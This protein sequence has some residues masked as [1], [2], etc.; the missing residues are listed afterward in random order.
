MKIPSNIHFLFLIVSVLALTVACRQEKKNKDENKISTGEAMQQ[1]SSKDWKQLF[2]KND[3]ELVID[4]DTISGED[5]FQVNNGKIKAMYRY[6]D[7]AV[8]PIAMII[9]KKKYSF[10]DL[11][12][13]YKWGNRKFRPRLDRKRDAGVLLHATTIQKVWPASLEYQIQEGDVGD[14][15]ALLGMHANV[16]KND[17]LIK[18][19]RKD[20]SRMLKF[21]DVEQLGWNKILIEVRGTA[22]KF[23][24]N[25]TLVNQ[26]IGANFK[27][28]SINEGHIALQAEHSEITY[29]KVF[30]K[31]VE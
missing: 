19:E 9:S 21:I 2:G 15:W 18:T 6:K 12:L 3:Y 22:L 16:L 10:Y 29:R 17:S 13:E 30:I 25:G 20:F 31:V 11:K 23:Y 26:L 27:G 24:L 28:S 7:S 8:S 1:K 5:I 4:S 14:F